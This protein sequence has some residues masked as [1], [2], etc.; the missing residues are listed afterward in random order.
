M[1][2]LLEVAKHGPRKAVRRKR[3]PGRKE[4][5]KCGAVEVVEF[6]IQG[7]SYM[8]ERKCSRRPRL[9]V[10]VVDKHG[11]P[12]RVGVCLRHVPKAK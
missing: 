11:R 2:D 8:M 4:K 3:S 1:V 10:R 6:V 12:L 9:T 5:Q 7:R